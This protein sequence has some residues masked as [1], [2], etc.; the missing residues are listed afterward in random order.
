MRGAF[1]GCT[2]GPAEPRRWPTG[3]V[4]ITVTGHGS[5]ARQEI[6]DEGWF[7]G[8]LVGDLAARVGDVALVPHTDIAFVDP[9]DTGELRLICRHGSLTAAEMWVPLLVGSG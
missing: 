1:D 4:S 6:E 5:R 3:R 8:P 9:T 7:G 2:P